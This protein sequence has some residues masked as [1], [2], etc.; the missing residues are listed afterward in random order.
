MNKFLMQIAV[1]MLV[2][3]SIN[4]VIKNKTLKLMIH[5]VI[6]IHQIVIKTLKVYIKKVQRQIKK[7]ITKKV[8]S[9]IKTRILPVPH[10]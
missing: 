6:K 8:S 4:L 10:H 5:K 3:K 2:A 7:M 1:M 9:T